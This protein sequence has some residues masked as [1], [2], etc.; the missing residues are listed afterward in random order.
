M[1]DKPLFTDEDVIFA[2]TRAE[3]L[4]DGV[5]RNL[6]ELAKEAGIKF[7]TAITAA[8]WA[9][10]IEPPDDCPDQSSEGRAW[11]VLQLLR[12]QAM[13]AGTSDRIDYLVRVQTSPGAWR[14]VALKALVHPGDSGEPVISI[15]LP[16]ED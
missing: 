15:M 9:A 11:D 12:W 10:V 14:D 6:S 1:N 2:Y 13:K 5:L 16:H 8:A 3:A 4:V 7:P